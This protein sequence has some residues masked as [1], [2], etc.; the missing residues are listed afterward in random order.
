M[1]F[2]VESAG[3]QLNYDELTHYQSVIAALA[4]TLHL[5]ADI[6]SAIAQAGGWPLR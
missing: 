2:K 5:Q 4:R 1:H 6:D 3:R